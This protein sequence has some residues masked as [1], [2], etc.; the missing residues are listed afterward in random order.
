M[1]TALLLLLPAL[2]AFTS[3]SAADPA[4]SKTVIGAANED[5]AAGADALRFGDYEEGIKLTLRGLQQ[6]PSPRDRAAA[7]SNLCAG[8]AA[9]DRLDLAIQHCNE[10]LR[11]NGRNWHAYHNRA[12]AHLFKGE[13][14]LAMK[15]V[16]AGL[17]LNPYSKKLQKVLEVTKREQLNPRVIMEEHP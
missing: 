15:D 9:T 17:E 2:A 6:H 4:A 12:T 11:L 1:R 14:D 16:K 7:L 5:L 10:S 13:L 3:A 8:Y